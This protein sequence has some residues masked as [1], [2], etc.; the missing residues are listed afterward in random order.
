MASRSDRSRSRDRS[1][2]P[3]SR[4]V[5]LPPRPVLLPANED[6][7]EVT[8]R[9]L[10]AVVAVGV[11]LR[12][13][14]NASQAAAWSTQAARAAQN[15]LLSLQRELSRLRYNPQEEQTPINQGQDSSSERKGAGRG[16]HQ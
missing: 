1:R 9:M 15:H 2:S 4:P 6:D 7:C 13:A 14:E 10:S 11:A 16:Q 12:E 5:L 8:Y 3:R